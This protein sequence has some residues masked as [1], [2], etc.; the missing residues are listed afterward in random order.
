M[1]DVLGTSVI[2]RCRTFWHSG[3]HVN[4]AVVNQLRLAKTT[5]SS[6]WGVEGDIAKTAWA[7]IRLAHCHTIKHSAE[8]CKMIAENLGTG[9]PRDAADEKLRGSA[10]SFCARPFDLWLGNQAG[11]QTVASL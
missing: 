4:D 2:K 6:G 11:R 8:L 3:F 5:V 1:T 7:P 9:V 10:K